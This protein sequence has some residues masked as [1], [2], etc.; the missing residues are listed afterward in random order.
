M[1]WKAAF[2][3]LLGEFEGVPEP[4]DLTIYGKS[5]AYSCHPST[6]LKKGFAALL[7]RSPLSM[8]FLSGATGEGTSTP[9]WAESS[10]LGSS[11]REPKEDPDLQHPQGRLPQLCIL[12]CPFKSQ[13]I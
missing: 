10:S 12:L 7:G 5:Y 3:D 2:T 11:D 4:A 8:S 13:S 1:S 6:Q 9:V